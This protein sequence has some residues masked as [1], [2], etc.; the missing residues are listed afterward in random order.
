MKIGEG[1]I[2][3][4]IEAAPDDRYPEERKLRAGQI[5]YVT[6]RFNQE[7]WWV[8]WYIDEPEQRFREDELQ[9]LKEG[10]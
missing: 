7:W 4:L 8:R 3:A 9:V 1:A 6:H 2:V 10:E 5:G